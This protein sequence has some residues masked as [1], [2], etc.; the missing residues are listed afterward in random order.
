[1]MPRQRFPT[2]TTLV[3][4]I[5]MGACGGRARDHSATTAR[6]GTTSGSSGSAAGASPGTGGSS[7][8][9]SGG[10]SGSESALANGASGAGRDS[11]TIALGGF[12]GTAAGGSGGANGHSPG[13]EAGAGG[14]AADC[15][16][17]WGTPPSDPGYRGIRGTL[18]GQPLEI[19]GK[20]T[21]VRIAFCLE[22]GP[23]PVPDL[24]IYFPLP[25]SS[26][27]VDHGCEARVTSPNE[28]TWHAL[29]T[30]IS[31]DV[32]E[33]TPNASDAWSDPSVLAWSEQPGVASG[34]LRL[35]GESGDGPFELAADFYLDVLEGAACTGPKVE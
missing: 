8:V 23:G 6:A 1:M 24:N 18:N 10:T 21:S 3:L 19:D 35:H 13:N 17:V 31:A 11:I 22:N 15:G 30:E 33:P 14:E 25:G 2:A 32:T 29:E 20:D 26:V 34:T 4:A 27:N 5:S 28:T 7:A 16:A 9:E 12:G